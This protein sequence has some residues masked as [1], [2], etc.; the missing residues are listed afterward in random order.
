MATTAPRVGCP[1]CGTILNAKAAGCD[2]EWHSANWDGLKH[3]EAFMWH[4]FPR[5]V[6]AA[7]G[8]AA[9]AAMNLLKMARDAVAAYWPILSYQVSSF[10]GLLES[11]GVDLTQTTPRE[12]IVASKGGAE[13]TSDV[14]EPA[15]E[16]EREE[17]VSL[18]DAAPEAEKAEDSSTD[19]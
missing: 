14:T 16:P 9:L 10:V 6:K 18:E 15:A 5:A 8:D 17:T 11:A 3:L 1:K 7:D 12:T 2:G 4:E 19:I 13:M